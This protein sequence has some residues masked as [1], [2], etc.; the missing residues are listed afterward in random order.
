M[1]KRNVN[2]VHTDAYQLGVQNL[3]ECFEGLKEHPKICTKVFVL[4]INESVCPM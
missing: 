4:N 1:I 2:Y 3:L